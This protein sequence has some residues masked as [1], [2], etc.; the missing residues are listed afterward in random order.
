MKQHI[1]RTNNNTNDINIKAEADLIWNT[2]DDILR[3]VFTRTEYP[4]IIYPLVLLRR[5][6]CV[7][8]STQDEVKQSLGES[9][10][11]LPK[12]AITK[13]VLDTCGFNNKTKWTLKKLTED[14]ETSLKD[15]F[16]TYLNGYTKNIT[17]IIDASGIRDD[18]NKLYTK[19]ILYP[20]LKKYAEIDLSPQ[21]VSNI[22]MGYI[23]EELVRRFSEQ[24]N[25]EAGEHYTPREV[26]QLM[27]KLLDIDEKGVRDG[28]LI[29]LY[30]PAC[31]TGGMLTTIHEYIEQINPKAN[32]RLNGQEVNDKTWAICEADM[33]LKGEQA[34]IVQND[35]LT[36]DGFPSDQ[37]DY[38]ICNPPYGKSWKTIQAKVKSRSNGRFEA[39]YPR[40]SDGQLLFLQHMIAKM[41]PKDMG[42]SAIAI[43][44][45]G[46]P[47]FT[48]D[49][50]SGESEIRRWII[51]NDWLETIIA[52]PTDLFYNTGIATYIWLVRN[53]KA[54]KRKGKV[55]LIN[56]VS[57][58]EKMGKSLGKKRNIISENQIEQ[59]IQLHKAFKAGEHSK[60][61]DNDDFAYH[62]VFLDLEER[63][64]SGKP[65]YVTK[66]IKL[67]AS[68]LKSIVQ[69]NK[70]ADKKKLETLIDKTDIDKSE[71]TFKLIAESEFIEQSKT[72]QTSI[73]IKK[74]VNNNRLSLSAE[75][76]VPLI[77]KDTE[78]IP[79]K[80]DVEAFLK[81][82]VE[83]P[84]T[85]TETKKGYEIPFAQHFYQYQPLRSADV[86]LKEFAA[87]E[88]QNAALLKE[89]SMDVV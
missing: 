6:E 15:N 77:V 89:L 54:D 71:F 12:Q 20:L 4:D 59:L 19:N 67:T 66:M 73:T 64:E 21:N 27:V 3:D 49:A 69:L 11:T 80:Q 17:N 35:T 43:V 81:A 44:L 55:Q 14:S 50:G 7:L 58:C 56:G 40:S 63:D 41:K 32:V 37:F 70:T 83:K 79:W 34:T 60:I 36:N 22:K 33:V 57:Y 28:E 42:G 46:S 47:L 86:V 9:Y 10:K 75:I 8:Q 16:I 48:G 5:I 38:M 2:A 29:R 39:G 25:A 13:K 65:V 87:L 52:L 23:F 30:D 62:K 1:N 61:F 31:G 74:E 53:N 84:W 76:E 68:K 26:I 72:P 78:I 45:N 82:E 24:N 88:K 51:E 85:I 18:I